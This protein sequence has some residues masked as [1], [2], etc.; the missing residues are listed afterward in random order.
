[1]TVELTTRRDY[2]TGNRRLILG[3]AIA[4]TLAGAVPVPFVDNWLVRRILGNAYR[5]IAAA[6]R[7]DL[8][9][10][11]IDNLV[12]G[13][14]SPASWTEMAGSAIAYRLAT[15]AWKRVLL[16]L[17]TVR[18]ARAAS[19]QFVVMTLFEHYCARLHVGLALDAPTALAVRETIAQ[20]ID[21][22]PGG[23]S[24]EPFRRG[25][26]SAARATLRAPLEL[27]DL[28]SGGRLRRL[29]ERNR[30]HDV[31]EPEQ[32]TALEQAIDEALAD[33]NNFL[34][35]AVTAVELQLSSEVNPYLDAVISRFDELWRRRRAPSPAPA[36]APA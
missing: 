20:A 6:H 13:K 9:A 25:A 33:H 1:V 23:L 31:A 24:F 34:A 14:S 26:R 15:V 18:R 36:P 10:D 3:R 21:Q 2:L 27:A 17:T 5:R 12:Y 30:D 19:R 35:R 29:L 11:S 28:A 8:E 32:V 4:G 22:T 16:A 7:V